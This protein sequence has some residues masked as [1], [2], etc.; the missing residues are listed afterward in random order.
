MTRPTAEPRAAYRHFSTLATRWG[1]NDV[2]GHVNN[3]VYYAYL[4]TAVNRYLVA[5]GALDI[6]HG[7]TVGFVIENRFNY[8]APLAFPQELDVGLRVGHVGRSSVRYE[9]GLFGEGEPLAAACG[10]FIH[11][12]VD[13]LTRRPVDLPAALR[14]ALQP[15]Q[16]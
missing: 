6:R 11:V 2:Y 7:S 5:S 9:I 10:Y 15:L 3:A 8:F 4:D 13:R 12:Y 16:T 14:A 1:D